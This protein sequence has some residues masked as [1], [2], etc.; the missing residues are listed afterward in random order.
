MNTLKTNRISVENLADVAAL[1][2]KRAMDARESAGIELSTEELEA[3]SGAAS[4]GAFQF[5]NTSTIKWNKFIVAG[6][7]IGGNLGGDFGGFGGGSIN[8]LG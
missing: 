5:P 8:P 4:L 3:I 2:A 6:G 7:N 1:S